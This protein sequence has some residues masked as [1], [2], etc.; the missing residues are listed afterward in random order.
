MSL[1][2]NSAQ[3]NQAI[4]FAAL[5]VADERERQAFLEQACAGDVERRHNIERLL[6]VGE[7]GTA[8]PLDRL[9]EQL[10]PA[11]ETAQKKGGG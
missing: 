3:S 10:D 11:H 9:L 8:S 1:D 2:I 7:P 4:Y 6:A 5:E